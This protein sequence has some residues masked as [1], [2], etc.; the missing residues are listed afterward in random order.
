MGYHTLRQGNWVLLQATQVGPRDE[1]IELGALWR[2][3]WVDR[4]QSR[5]GSEDER[6]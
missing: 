2:V 6:W 4:G 5:Q 1:R 3:A